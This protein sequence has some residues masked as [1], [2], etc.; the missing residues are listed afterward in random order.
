MA[1]YFIGAMYFDWG[2]HGGSYMAIAALRG[3]DLF[4]FPIL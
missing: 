2:C 4:G 1:A 3:V